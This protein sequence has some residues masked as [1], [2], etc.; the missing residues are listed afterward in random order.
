MFA[1]AASTV[2]KSGLAPDH[3]KDLVPVKP[4][5]DIESLVVEAYRNKLAAV[6]E[7]IRP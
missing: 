7:K 5:A 3:V 4:L 2:V 1:G 6:F